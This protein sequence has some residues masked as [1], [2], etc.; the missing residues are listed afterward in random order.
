MGGDYTRFTFDPVK[1]F[2]GVHKQQGRV[3]LDSDFNEL[4]EILDRRDRAETY[5]TVGQAVVPVTT[6]DG[7]AIGVNGAGKLTIGRGRMYVDGI[8]AEC[9][10]DLSDPTN[11]TFRPNI[12]YVEGNDPLVF[13]SQPFW[14]T[15][16]PFP[17]LSPTPGVIN[18]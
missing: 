18:L 10:G 3:S 16:P 9:F 8:L 17:S 1:G 15:N 11:T 14:Y 5:D 6:P 13:E 2:S 12:G 7:F 4:E